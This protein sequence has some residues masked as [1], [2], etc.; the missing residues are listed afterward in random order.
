M[1]SK[2]LFK[3]MGVLILAVVMLSLLT[4]YLLL[5]KLNLEQTEKSFDVFDKYESVGYTAKF[6]NKDISYL[7]TQDGIVD[8]SKI[9]TYL[10]NYNLKFGLLNIS[11]KVQYHVID[12]IPPEINLEGGNEYSV[13]SLTSFKE[14]GYTAMDNYDGDITN[15]VNIS[16]NDD[17]VT[18]DVNDSSGNNANVVRKLLVSDTE[19]PSLKLNG[20][21]TIYLPLNTEYKELGAVASDNCAGDLSSKIV[22]EGKVNTSKLAT[23]KLNYSVTD[24]FDNTA[25]VSRK[26]II[27]D[28]NSNQ[29]NSSGVIYLTFDDGPGS[30][31][32]QILDILDKYSIK[33]T[34]FV[35]SAGNDATIL[36]EY[37][38]GHT[39][40]LHTSTH[41][42]SIYSSVDAY[43]NDLNI[44]ANRVKSITGHD[45]SFI[46]FPGGSSN[47]ISKHYQLG[48][49]TTLA[50]E[51][52]NRGYKYFDWNVCVED[53]GACAKKGIKN[54]EACV[55]NYFESGLSKSRNNYVLLHDIK[56]Y[57][58]NSLETM[59]QYA[60]SQG[61]TFKNIDMN[62]I[63]YHQKLNN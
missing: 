34:F 10:V 18:Y 3:I 59:I 6:L 28:P 23:Y 43:F 7:V 51:V 63:P 17:E 26:V 36:R 5:P 19:K 55:V 52:E 39:V 11:K 50:S 42:W 41:Q 31:T 54:R 14:P 38:S 48:I 53:A 15:N 46:R 58:A 8:T 60:L 2:K 20:E 30:Y 57:T 61:Y 16:L 27:Y 24:D 40:G 33:A 32:N 12:T 4:F 44:V 62:T 56:S 35:T 21:S 1:L 49:M 9:G 25:E 13:C 22:I 29:Y 45:A 37:Q 47:T